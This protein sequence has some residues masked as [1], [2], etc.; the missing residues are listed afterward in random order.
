MTQL[1]TILNKDRNYTDSQ[2]MFLNNLC[3]PSYE[4]DTL[5]ALLD[6][7]YSASSHASVVRSL[8]DEIIEISKTN[9]V[10]VLPDAVRKL[11]SG[12]NV[13]LGHNQMKAVLEVMDRAGLNKKEEKTVSHE[14]KHAVVILPAKENLDIVE[15]DAE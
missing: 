9:L 14:H 1:P 12:M 8:Q 4:L 13:E 10:S 11:I 5:S 3:D 2:L 6:A 15:I 7:G